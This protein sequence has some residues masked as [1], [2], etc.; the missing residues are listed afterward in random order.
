MTSDRRAVVIG[1]SRGIG[2]AVVE[3]LATDGL[4]VLATGRDG[5]ALRRLEQEMAARGLEVET[6]VADATDEV[7][8]QDLASRAGDT[9][10]LVFNA[11]ASTAAP[12]A[13]TDLA[14]WEH[15]LA[16]NATGAFLALRAFVPPMVARRSGRVVVVASTAAVSGSPYISAYAAA[17]HAA[18]GL[19]RSV[20]AEVAGSGVAVNAVC[21]HFVRSDMTDA[22]IERIRRAT[23]RDEAEARAQ[24]EGSSRL[25]RLIEPDEVAAAVATLVRE[26]GAPVNGQALVMDGG[27]HW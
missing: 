16:V 7:A 11:G 19:V 27:G 13:R 25:G 2:R 23:G 8:T 24:L 12:L 9:D 4:H 3:R 15:V 21:P 26:D 14:T 18:L 20:A 22:S 5:G 6:L 1:G 17:K 10:V